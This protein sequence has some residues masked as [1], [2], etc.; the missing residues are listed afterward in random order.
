MSSDVNYDAL[1]ALLPMQVRVYVVLGLQILAAFLAFTTA[2][3]P[4]V[5]R[6]VK[7]T[8]TDKDDQALNTVQ[9]VLSVIPRVQL[10]ALS[11][12]PPKPAPTNIQ[13]SAWPDTSKLAA[14]AKPGPEIV[15]PAPPA[16]DESRK[17]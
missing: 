17:G 3:M 7:M 13:V 1:I 12:P 10:P 9:R 11:N 15:P 16:P 6:I 4:L 2:V 14:P 5:E 8:K